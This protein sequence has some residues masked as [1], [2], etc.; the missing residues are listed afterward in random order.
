MIQILV[1]IQNAYLQVQNIKSGIIIICFF[2]FV[3]NAL[4][5][6]NL[7][8]MRNLKKPF[9]KKKKRKWIFMFLLSRSSLSSKIQ[10]NYF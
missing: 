1:H 3:Q 6:Y 9:K 5:N 7:A 4:V 2:I 8:L 10:L